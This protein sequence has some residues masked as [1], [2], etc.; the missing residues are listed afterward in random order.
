[1]K[2]NKINYLLIFILTIFFS[3]NVNA[4][5]LFIK[6]KEVYLSK[7]MCGSCHALLDAKSEGQIGPNLD[8][9][10]P[11][12][13][14]I[15]YAVKNGIGVMPSFEGILTKNEIEAVAHYVSTSSS[16]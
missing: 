16:K 3:L 8:D 13:A 2:A 11:D 6:G 4:D 5:D 12:T 10:K 7:G 9:L 14:K 1:M 15:I